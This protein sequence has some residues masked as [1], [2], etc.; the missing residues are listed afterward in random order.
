M[1]SAEGWLRQRRKVRGIATRARHLRRET[2]E[3]RRR[4]RAWFFRIGRPEIL[5]WSFAAGLVWASGRG[6]TPRRVA[7][8]RTLLRLANSILLVWELVHRV[9]STGA[10]LGLGRANPR[11]GPPADLPPLARGP[12]G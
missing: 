11:R 12:H 9:R 6:Q 3:I 4:M 5:G 8:E 10:A 1:V 7:R 2:R